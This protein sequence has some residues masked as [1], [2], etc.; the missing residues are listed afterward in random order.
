[1]GEWKYSSTILD[2]GTRLEWPA[3]RSDRFIAGTD[4]LGGWVGARASLDV[5]MIKI[6]PLPGFE[7]QLVASKNNVIALEF[8]FHIYHYG[9][10]ISFTNNHFHT[11]VPAALVA[12]FILPRDITQ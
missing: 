7:P 9:T 1:M 11:F 8:F 3:S 2:L 12:L 10:E 5:V 6:L 4:W